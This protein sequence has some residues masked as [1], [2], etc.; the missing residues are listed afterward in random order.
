MEKLKEHILNLSNISVN[1]F[2]GDFIFAIVNEQLRHEDFINE[3]NRLM[4]ENYF[5]TLWL[6]F[7]ILNAL[8]VIYTCN[9]PEDTGFF[10]PFAYIGNGTTKPDKNNLNWGRFYWTDSPQISKREK[11]IIK[12]RRIQNFNGYPIKVNQFFRYPTALYRHLTP[13]V[14]LDSYFYKPINMSNGGEFL[15]IKCTCYKSIGMI[16][17]KSSIVIDSRKVKTC[18]KYYRGRLE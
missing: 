11:Q 10:D 2:D 7:N 13:S 4:L 1:S 17:P 14:L 6:D 8:L 5:R 16:E 18:S 9:G 15:L 12:K 3:T